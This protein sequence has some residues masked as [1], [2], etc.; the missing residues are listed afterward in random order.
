M[1]IIFFGTPAFAVPSL[2]ALQEAG[3]EVVAVVTQ[4]DRSHGRSR[5]VVVAPPVKL[6]ADKTGLPVLQPDKPVGVQLIDQLTALGADLGVVVAY[7]HILRPQVLVIPRLGMI[8]VHA[9]LLPRW[10]GA[11]P[12]QWAIRSGDRTTG[13]TIMQM[14]AGLDSGPA[15]HARATPIG[16]GETGGGLT[17]RLSVLGAES[18]LEA[19]PRLE[20]GARPVAQD[21]TAVT[22]APKIDRGSARIDWNESATTLSHHAAAFDPVP[23][24]WTTLGGMDVKLFQARM[25]EMTG[26]QTAPGTILRAD[27]EL[28]ITTGEGTLLVREVQPAGKTRQPVA[29]WVRGRG[30]AAGARFT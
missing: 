27:D 20:S 14:E 13:I 8:N 2:R 23:G 10:R 1:R 5:S 28:E 17:E 25:A 24:A 19:L 26:N 12:I 9:S 3:H 15:W 29:A 7:G 18:L 21:E 22:F 4:P 16:P 6:V 30:V 11:A